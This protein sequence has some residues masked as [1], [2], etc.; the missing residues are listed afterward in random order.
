M[1]FNLFPKQKKAIEDCTGR[2]HILARSVSSGK[3]HGPYE[4]WARYLLFSAPKGDLLMTRRTLKSLER[5]VL[6]PMQGLIPLTYSLHS[7]RADILG[8]RIRLEGA[9]HRQSESMITGRTIA[10]HYGDR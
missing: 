9:N 5:N 6:L 2:I 3:T 1:P 8:R 4:W 7:K 10:G